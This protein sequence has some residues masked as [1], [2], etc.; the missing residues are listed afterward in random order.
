VYG[1]VNEKEESGMPKITAT[2]LESRSLMLPLI[3]YFH[4]EKR[5]NGE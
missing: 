1:A 3:P 4:N 5:I 2:I